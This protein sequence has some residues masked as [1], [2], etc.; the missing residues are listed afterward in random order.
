LLSGRR[1]PRHPAARGRTLAV[2]LGTAALVLT[3]AGLLR[4]P[5][6]LAAVAVFYGLYHV[7]LVVVSAR[8]QLRIE[9]SSRATV[10]SVAA[11]G[12]EVSVFAIYAAWA[13]GGVV[14]IAI[15]VL[16][17]AA[18]L[19]RLLGTPDPTAARQSC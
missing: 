4:A 10:A 18:A 12:T 8:L 1:H 17:V 11:V 2:L 9:A 16:V 6:G 5:A 7:V 15:L 3:A 19:P 14:L 13:L